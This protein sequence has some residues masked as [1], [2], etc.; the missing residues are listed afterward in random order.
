VGFVTSKKDSLKSS[1]EE[2]WLTLLDD[3][4]LIHQ[5]QLFTPLLGN[6]IWWLVTISKKNKCLAQ[7]DSAT[8]SIWQDPRLSNW[9]FRKRLLLEISKQKNYS[10]PFTI[11][12]ANPVSRTH[13]IPLLDDDQNQ[14]LIAITGYGNGVQSNAEEE[15]ILAIL[16]ANIKSILIAAAQSIEL[17]KV[18]ESLRPRIVA[19]STVHTMHRLIN[20]SMSLDEIYQKLAHLTAQVLRSKECTIMIMEREKRIKRLVERGTSKKKSKNHRIRVMKSREGMEGKVFSTAKHVLRKNLLCVPLIDEDVLG[21]VTL[22]GKRD[23]KPFNFFDKEI[24]M[25]LCEEAVVAIKNAQLYEEQKRVTLETIQSLA[26]ILGSRMS[27]HRKIQS[28]TLLS[29]VSEM[30][31]TLKLRDDDFQ[32]LQY[33]TILK[34]A[35][36]FSMPDKILNNNSKLSGKEYQLLKQHPAHGAK[37]IETFRNLRPVAPIILASH[38]NYDGTGYPNGLKGHQIPLG[39]RILA[40]L[41]AFEALASGRPYKRDAGLKQAFEEL[42]QNRG[43]QFDPHVVDAFF[44]VV[45]KIRIMRM[46]MRDTKTTEKIKIPAII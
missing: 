7:L 46:L 4:A 22:K 35:S 42:I 32:A 29:I 33:A 45:A 27:H 18:K 20:A 24:L 39:S 34:D 5:R 23:S 8:L 19:L 17:K 28:G 9:P 15:S 25:T 1:P 11:S 13:C 3:K 30:A 14:R 21:V 44:K 36:K 38:E 37:M 6:P 26:N 31:K 43:T 16:H 10:L 12:E 41:N 2:L 40:V